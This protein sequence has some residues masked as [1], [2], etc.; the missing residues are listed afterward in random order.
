MKNDKD[1]PKDEQTGRKVEGFDGIETDNPNVKLSDDGEFA[2]VALKKPLT[3]ARFGKLLNG[4]ENSKLSKDKSLEL[5]RMRVPRVHDRIAVSKMPGAL[6]NN[7]V[8]E[9]QL[10]ARIADLPQNVLEQLTGS[11][12]DSVQDA[13]GKLTD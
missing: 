5:I 13:L 2:V 3:Q 12:W 9:Y 7:V 10:V 1:E 4:V 8:F 6:G 11:D